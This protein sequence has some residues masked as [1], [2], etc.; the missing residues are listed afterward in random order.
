MKKTLLFIGLLLLMS[1]C[2]DKE[3]D[4][5]N[6]ELNSD[7]QDKVEV[8]RPSAELLAEY[9]KENP[10]T[11]VEI[12]Q[13]SIG[14]PLELVPIFMG[15]K[16]FNTA[17]F[18]IYILADGF[19][20]GEQSIFNA[21]AQDVKNSITS[22]SPFSENLDK[23]NFYRVNSESNETGV[24]S[25][26]ATGTYYEI[27]K[28]THWK[29]YVNNQGLPHFYGIPVES[30]NKIRDLYSK[31]SKGEQVYII[32][33]SNNPNYGGY[34]EFNA[35]VED[36][37]PLMI[38][39]RN[40]SSFSF[41]TRHEF[42]HSFSALDDEYVDSDFANSEAGQ[43]YLNNF[44]NALNVKDYNP[45]G[46]YKGARYVSWKYRFGNAL[47]RG[48]LLTY[49]SRNEGLVQDRINEEAITVICSKAV[50]PQYPNAT[51]VN[52]HAFRRIDGTGG[53][54]H[55]VDLS[56]GHQ[57]KFFKSDYKTCGTFGWS[58]QRSSQWNSEL[59]DL[60][61]NPDFYN[62]SEYQDWDSLLVQA[63]EPP[64]IDPI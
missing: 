9:L 50:N 49:H 13:K 43:N 22:L 54:W 12:N 42:G 41:L 32:V 15:S 2:Q 59:A 6:G 3:F 61:A 48:T 58:S 52:D 57:G 30:R 24:S 36:N 37:I 55:Y 18:K 26:D 11:K 34:G 39:S 1:A 47:M 51:I 45:G 63:S 25:L 31:D 60:Y 29:T 64:I 16:P 10:P 56:D 21:Y 53:E 44:P 20:S 5:L 8:I 28:D 23:I 33:I 46:W 4:Q 19:T 27:V 7:S 17:H 40:S 14:N 35:Y 38:T 62:I